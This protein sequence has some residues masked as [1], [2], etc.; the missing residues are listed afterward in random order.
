MSKRPA[1]SSAARDALRAF[2]PKLVDLTDN[3]LFG[4]VWERPGLSQTSPNST[5]SVKSTSLG[6]KARK[7]SRA[8][9]ESAGLLDMFL[10]S[11]TSNSWIRG[12]RDR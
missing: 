11:S 9:D 3:V 8:A 10:S 7:A 2:A 6:A 5:L 1:D 4:D 12:W